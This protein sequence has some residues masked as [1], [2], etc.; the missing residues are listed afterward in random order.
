M[1]L[2]AVLRF[3]GLLCVSTNVSKRAGV[4]SGN[5]EGA[6]F[7]KGLGYDPSKNVKGDGF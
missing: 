2:Y 6:C 5:F 1:I 4:L 7:S 3:I